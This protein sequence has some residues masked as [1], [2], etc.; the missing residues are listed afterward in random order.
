MSTSAAASPVIHSMDQ[1]ENNL[2]GR[3]QFRA[4]S[5]ADFEI[6]VELRIAAM[7]E[8]LERLGRFDPERARERLRKTFVPEFTHFINCDDRVVGFYVLRPAADGLHLDHFYIHPSAQNQKIGSHV[9]GML[10]ENNTQPPR[11]IYVGA[12]K[13]SASNRFYLRHGFEK[14]SEDEWDNYYVLPPGLDS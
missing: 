1:H 5:A 6:L 14:K 12:L 13:E 4:A 3:V 2:H 8:S 11:P 9:L 7:R 10:I